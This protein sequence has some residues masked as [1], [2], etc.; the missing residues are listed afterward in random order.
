MGNFTDYWRR[1]LNRGLLRP[2]SQSQNAFPAPQPVFT[3]DKMDHFVDSAKVPYLL[4]R[5]SRAPDNANPR[6]KRSRRKPEH[7]EGRDPGGRTREAWHDYRT[8]P[9]SD[10]GVGNFIFGL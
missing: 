2:K 9:A 6:Q 5:V 8:A 10:P 3:L 7:G 1:P 4:A